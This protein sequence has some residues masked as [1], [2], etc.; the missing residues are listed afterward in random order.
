MQKLIDQ[1]I[2]S[3]KNSWAPKSCTTERSRLNGLTMELI[4]NPDVLYKHLVEKDNLQPYAVKTKFIRIGDFYEWAMGAGHIKSGRNVIKDYMKDHANRFKNAYSKKP[5]GVSFEEARR[6]IAKIND[7][8]AKM[9][10][11][12]L[13]LTGMRYEES[14]TLDAKGMIV[15][16]GGKRRH[17]PNAPTVEY[18]KTYGAFYHQ[19]K[20]VGLT[21]HVLRKAHANELVDLGATIPD[22]MSLMG[23]SSVQT[24]ASYLEAHSKNELVEKFKSVHGDLKKKI[25]E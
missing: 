10:A 6:R 13:L 1:Y 7:E 9:K 22:L 23:W 21:P 8:A 11:L 15:G 14:T 16:K 17:V 18:D 5:T 12:Q 19:L 3:K 20:K 24:P 25:K 4:K 2:E